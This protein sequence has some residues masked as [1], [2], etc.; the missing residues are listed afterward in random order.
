[1]ET[2]ID[3]KTIFRKD[4]KTY[5]FILKRDGAPINLTGLTVYLS[6]KTE[7]DGTELFS[8]TGSLS[9]PTEGR[10]QVTLSSSDTAI[11][12]NNAIAEVMIEDG[13]GK[14][15]TLGQFYID[16]VKDVKTD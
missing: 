15:D 11:L 2:V 13:S 1:M 4:T 3:K 14:Q 9:S 8:R 16:I 12:C 10:C 5:N 7:A 6:A